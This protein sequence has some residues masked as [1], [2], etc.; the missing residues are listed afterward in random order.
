MSKSYQLGNEF[1]QKHIFVEILLEL[2]PIAKLETWKICPL[3]KPQERMQCVLLCNCAEHW[4]S[5]WIQGSLNLGMLSAKIMRLLLFSAASSP[6]KRVRFSTGRCLTIRSLT[7][8]KRFCT[9]VRLK[10]FTH[11][12]Q[13]I[14][15][16]YMRDS[17]ESSS[18]TFSFP[19]LMPVFS[20]PTLHGHSYCSLRGETKC[21]QPLSDVPEHKTQKIN[22]GKITPM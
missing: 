13:T 2:S 12:H 10:Q 20:L 3:L 1:L 11:S 7:F 17:S 5:C 6:I 21:T 16:P 9:K 15:L 18:E 22:F 4:F 19:I 14:Q 8:Q